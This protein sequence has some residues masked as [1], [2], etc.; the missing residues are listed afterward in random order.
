MSIRPPADSAGDES[1]PL[2]RECDGSSEVSILRR[3]LRHAQ[4]NIS[5]LQDQHKSTLADLHGELD[6]LKMQNK[7]QQWRLVLAGQY[8][9]VAAEQDF[10][11]KFSNL[12]TQTEPPPEP[13]ATLRLKRTEEDNADLRSEI[14]YLRK[15]NE[16]YKSEVLNQSKKLEISS[17]QPEPRRLIKPNYRSRFSPRAATVS[18]L[19]V[20]SRPGYPA[21]QNLP[22]IEGALTE[23]GEEGRAKTVTLPALRGVNQNLKHQR[24]LDAI[25]FRKLN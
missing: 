9:S 7:E 1:S 25:N 22:A 18:N 8:G 14:E 5:F 10:I 12:S 3:R 17:R 24:R 11:H 6:R 15:A 13:E 4:Q 20:I 2:D 19:R 16:R 21:S 23:S